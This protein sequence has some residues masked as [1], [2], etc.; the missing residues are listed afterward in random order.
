MPQARERRLALA[1]LELARQVPR[2]DQNSGDAAVRPAERQRREGE[3]ERGSVPPR[4]PHFESGQ[5]LSRE[6]T[7]EQLRVRRGLLRPAGAR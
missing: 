1:H 6:E 7:R 3:G 5:G 2:G 4:L